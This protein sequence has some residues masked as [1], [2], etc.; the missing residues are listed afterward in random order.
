MFKLEKKTLK[1]VDE[2]INSPD[3]ILTLE[4]DITD[5]MIVGVLTLSNGESK[6]IQFDKTKEENL[7]KGRLT[8]DASLTEY[9]TYASFKLSLIHNTYSEFTNEVD[10][11]FD[12]KSI[13]KEIKKNQ[14]S[15]IVKLS[16][17]LKKL[18]STLNTLC[19]GHI[20]TNINIVNKELVKKG[21]IPTAIDDQGNFA[22][23]YP[24]GNMVTEIN[25]R[26]PV[27]GIVIIDSSMLK[28]KEKV[29][30]EAYLENL[31]NALDKTY[32]SLKQLS[33]KFK[34]LSKKVNDLD[35]K[36]SRHINGGII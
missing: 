22:L 11:K 7:F 4:S 8:L 5:C 16:I 6:V 24:F 35:I 19:K 34:S 33:D 21:M 10:L 2:L 1:A 36:I 9:L 18:E 15:E 12:K 25:G 30:V 14:S 3:Y 20:L 28:Y 27:N 13:L 26:T 17:E 31:T 32:E 29:S 23:C